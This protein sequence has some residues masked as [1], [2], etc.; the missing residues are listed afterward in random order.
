M[1]EMSY[2]ESTNTIYIFIFYSFV[3]QKSITWFEMGFDEG[4]DGVA[5]CQVVDTD[6]HKVFTHLRLP[7]QLVELKKRVSGGTGRKENDERGW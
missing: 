2:N 1:S 3:S 5:W 4:Q 6:T 7:E